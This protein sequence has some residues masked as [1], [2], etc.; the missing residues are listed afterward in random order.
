MPTPP[1]AITWADLL[2]APFTAKSKVRNIKK[3]VHP[4]LDGRGIFPLACAFWCCA[5]WRI[6]TVKPYSV[7]PY[8]RIKIDYLQ[9]RRAAE[10]PEI[11]WFFR[12]PVSNS[13]TSKLAR[14]VGSG[15]PDVTPLAEIAHVGSPNAANEPTVGLENATNEP[16][17]AAEIVSAQSGDPNVGTDDR[18]EAVVSIGISP[19]GV[20]NGGPGSI[21]WL[22]GVMSD[23]IRRFWGWASPWWWCAQTAW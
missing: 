14:R 2:A 4:P 5:I 17:I 23:L 3:E 1:R 21:K 13:A 20:R 19:K 18:G 10:T 11:Q 22:G 8:E 16:K 6:G 9:T 15:A 12:M 7:G